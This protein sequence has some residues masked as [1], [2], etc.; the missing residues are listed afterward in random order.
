MSE[1]AKQIEQYRKEKKR[2]DAWLD[3]INRRTS[4]LAAQIRA[5]EAL[6]KQSTAQ[7]V[8]PEDV[9]NYLDSLLPAN[10]SEPAQAPLVVSN[11]PYVDPSQKTH[12]VLTL[13]HY[14][15]RKELTSGEVVQLVADQGYKMSKDDVYKVLSRQRNMGRLKKRA[16]KFSLTDAGTKTLKILAKARTWYS[17]CNISAWW[18]ADNASVFG[19]KAN[20]DVDYCPV[21]KSS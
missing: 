3:R 12:L 9:L 1:F 14:A 7:T 17:R 19:S 11:P 8:I 2:L 20:S 18:P 6:E 4:E 21:K 13:I 15:K 5:L 16:N 10:G